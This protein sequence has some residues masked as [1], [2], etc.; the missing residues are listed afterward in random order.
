MKREKEPIAEKIEGQAT[1][2]FLTPPLILIFITI[3]IDLIGF[4]MVIPILPF[5]SKVEPF[6]ASPF[7]I[8]LLVSIFSWMQVFFTPVFGALSDR[9]GRKP[10]LVLSLVGSAFGYL[11]VGLA[12]SLLM[13][14][15]GRA[16][17]GIAG[18]SISTA[19]AYVADVTTRENRAKGMG[20]FGA[21]FG[22]GFIL[23]PALAGILS[24]WG[25]S[26]PF[27]FAAV[28]SIANAVA[29]F[30]ILPESLEPELRRKVEADTERKGRL[31]EMVEVLEGKDFRVVAIVYFLLISA[32]SIMTYAYVLGTEFAFGYGAEEN[33][34]LFFFVGLI[35]IVMQGFVFGR[36]A[37]SFGEAPLAVVGCI[38]LTIGLLAI[39]FSTPAFGGLAGL[40]FVSALLASGNAFATPAL[41]TMGSKIAAA[42]VQG[43]AMGVLQSLAS[44]ARAI[45]PTIGGVLL[46]NQASQIDR[47]TVFRTYWVA[48]GIMFVA[49]L[50]AAYA[51]RHLRGKV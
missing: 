1:E 51:A 16:I 46:S 10:L 33:G 40:L 49:F 32:F 6:M 7:E 27:Y 44:L 17:G 18:G 24:K 14:F 35:S 20:L 42:H 23:G 3:F 25:I 37:K 34:Y 15:A 29:V 48:A 28:L 2:K 11:V 13:V 26:T 43:R 22:L 39:P 9:F 5:Y 50:V 45:G 21:A 47:S 4:G 38:I 30:L 19:Q 36:M 41:S 8:G 12:G 31:A